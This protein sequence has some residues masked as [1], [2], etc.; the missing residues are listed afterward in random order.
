M[1][2]TVQH[3]SARQGNVATHAVLQDQVGFLGQSKLL[4]IAQQGCV[5]QV[6]GSS[7]FTQDG[8]SVMLTVATSSAL[9]S[10]T[11]L[12]FPRPPPLDPNVA[13]ASYPYSLLGLGDVAV[14]GLLACLC[15]RYD[16]SR[17][18]DLRPRAEASM[19]AIEQAM[20]ELPQGAD[21]QQMG[22]A[23]ASAAH[24]AYDK[25]ADADDARRAA[26]TTWGTQQRTTD[27]DQQPEAR[28][29]SFASSSNSIADGSA[30]SSS[31]ADPA[32]DV[33]AVTDAVLQQRRYFGPVMLAYSAGLV[34]SYVANY[35]TRSGQPALLYLCPLTFGAVVAVALSRGELTR[36][37]SFTDTPS[38]QAST[39]SQD[40][41]S[42]GA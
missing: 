28:S 14:P 41:S 21:K 16:A 34:V 5:L 17:T 42:S 36:V 38:M 13:A 3:S 37:L 4:Q 20:A 6:F 27:A 25:L 9:D 15:L 18:V 22:E 40:D 1:A 10:P 2:C 7:A 33:H 32:P 12:L 35:V 11:R 19:A 31:S 26:T 24:A 29:D 30:P 39:S 23:A 8:Q